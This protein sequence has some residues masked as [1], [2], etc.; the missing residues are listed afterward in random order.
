MPRKARRSVGGIV[1]HVLN[2]ANARRRLFYRDA[3]YVAFFKALAETRERWP[4]VELFSLCVM[5]NHWHLVLRPQRDG[6]LSRFMGWLTQTHTQR[7]RHAK[8]TVG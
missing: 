8:H 4:G 6:E 2:R 5:P 1:Y 7:W 3:D